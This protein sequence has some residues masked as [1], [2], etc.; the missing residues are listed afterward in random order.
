MID[1]ILAAVDPSDHGIRVMDYS[2]QVGSIFGSSIQALSVIDS[3]KVE[4]PGLRDYLAS[5]GLDP[6]MTYRTK[7]ETFYQEKLGQLLQ[8]FQSRCQ[9]A[10][11]AYESSLEKGVVHKMI[12]DRAS[13]FDLII[14]GKLGEHAEW[15][16]DS[17]GGSVSHV[18]RRAKKPL[19]I[20]PKRHIPMAN[21]LVAYDGSS[22]SRSALELAAEIGGRTNLRGAVLIVGGE[23]KHKKLT[24]EAAKVL[25]NDSVDFEVITRPGEGEVA[26]EILNAGDTMDA[27]LII[28]GAYGHGR[29]HNLILGSTTEEVISRSRIPVLLRH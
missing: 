6:D 28:M 12:C 24:A 2:I 18:A 3:K 27:D 22:F 19:L 16:A 29:I 7:V 25:A 20:T 13:S 1:S 17:L 14:M 8:E 10:G 5:V 26:S 11:L 21:A 15:S 23:D 4:G 9:E